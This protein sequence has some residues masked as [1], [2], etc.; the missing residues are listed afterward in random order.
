ML[1]RAAIRVIRYEGGVRETEGSGSR[2]LS[3]VTLIIAWTFLDGELLD[4]GHIRQSIGSSNSSGNWSSRNN[5]NDEMGYSLRGKGLP[6][7]LSVVVLL[8]VNATDGR[9]YSV[10]EAFLYNVR[11][12]S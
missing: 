2:G 4:M 6:P 8:Q 12:A 7:G 3:A 11:F 5:I 1:R 10:P 9:N